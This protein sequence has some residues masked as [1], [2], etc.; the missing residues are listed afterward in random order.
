MIGKT[1]GNYEI[2]SELAEGGMGAVYRARHRNLPR[3]VVIKCILLGG[4][5]QGTHDL[6]RARF[7]REACVHSQLDHPNIVRIHEFFVAEENYY[8]VM[9]YVAGLSLAQLL[10]Q[11]G[12]LTESQSIQLFRQAL[13]GMEYAHNFRYQDETQTSHTGIVHRD[14]KPGNMLLDGQARLKITD[15]GIVKVENESGLTQSGFNPGTVAYMSP[16]QLCGMKLDARSDIYSLGV[17]FYE[18]LAGRLPFG[19]SRAGSDYEIRKGHIE[20]EPPPL[21]EFT[22]EIPPALNDVVMRSLRKKPED[23]YQTALEFLEAIH[24]Y[25]Q[26]IA[27]QR[28]AGAPVDNTMDTIRQ[29]VLAANASRPAPTPVNGPRPSAAAPGQTGQPASAPYGTQATRP[30]AQQ[31]Q[32][33]GAP[34]RVSVPLQQTTS[35]RREEPQAASGG[36]GKMIAAAGV[37]ALVLAGAA[38][39]MLRPEKTSNETANNHTSAPAPTP[40]T[41][42]YMPS[43]PGGASGPGTESGPETGT[44]TSAAPTDGGQPTGAALP[45][46]ATSATPETVT[47][48]D[49]SSVR[50]GRDHE[51]QE[52]YRDAIASYEAF[53]RNHPNAPTASAVSGQLGQLKQFYATLATARQQLEQRDYEGAERDFKQAMML[54]PDSRQARTGYEDARTGLRRER[55]RLAEEAAEATR[56][57]QRSGGQGQPMHLPMPPIMGPPPSGMPLPQGPLGGGPI[58]PRRP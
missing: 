58:L 25:E 40:A 52:R 42:Y 38:V 45:Q 15:F 17:T 12:R 33:P 56:N 28:E 6:L 9:E 16:E 29:T 47:A 46:A 50:D 18:M 4:F 30:R 5:S 55:E 41:V 19:G 44:Q 57:Q 14:I 20:L 22:P 43:Q 2:T 26:D 13:S 31:G 49:D 7:I 21:M 35:F 37:L 23:R 51:A 27:S 53:L 8:L 10:Q 36:K 39:P 32:A 1:I 54:R 24:L 48:L 11:R 34:M 3:E